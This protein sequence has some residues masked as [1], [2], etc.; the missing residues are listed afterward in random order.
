MVNAGYEFSTVLVNNNTGGT[1]YTEEMCD[2]VD[3]YRLDVQDIEDNTIYNTIKTSYSD[4]YHDNNNNP[5]M[6]RI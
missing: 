1:D 6:Y 5:V 2:V 4:A 3:A